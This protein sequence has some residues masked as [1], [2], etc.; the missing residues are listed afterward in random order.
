MLSHG[1]Y[2]MSCSWDRTR[3]RRITSPTRHCATLPLTETEGQR[4]ENRDRERQREE[5][6]DREMRTEIERD[7]EMRKEKER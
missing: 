6:R 1:N 7:R 2:N 4:D 3:T 5:N